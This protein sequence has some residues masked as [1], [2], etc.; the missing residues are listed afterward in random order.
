MFE[1]GSFIESLLDPELPPPEGLRIGCRPAGRRFS[2]YRNNV[3][4]GLS[5]VLVSGFPVLAKLLGEEFFR[6]MAAAFV[7]RHPPRSPVLMRYGEEMP[8]F[9]AEFPP[10]RGYPYLPDVARL[11]LAL[12]T[13]YHA[14]DAEPVAAE[15]IQGMSESEIEGARLELSPAVSQLRS[16]YPVCSIWMVNTGGGRLS[17]SSGGEDVLIVRKEFDPDPMIHFPGGYEFIESVQ[18]G[19][20]LVLASE[21]ASDAC[22]EFDL[23][24]MFG[25]LLSYNAVTALRSPE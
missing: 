5:D 17:S 4:V 23:S 20:P 7:R 15:S 3:V 8:D 16:A 6:A 14:A 22:P 10:V 21:A 25:R 9:L 18:N 13:S 1:Q 19:A 12:R 2:V 24:A 11:E